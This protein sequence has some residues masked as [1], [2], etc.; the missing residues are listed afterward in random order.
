M[1]K[2][3]RTRKATPAGVTCSCLVLCDDVQVNYAT[4]KHTLHGII[5]GMVAR[6]LPMGVGPCVAYVRLSNVHSNQRVLI[7]FEHAD[8]ST[9]LWA[10][11]A[12]LIN[13]NDPLAVHTLMTRV[14]PFLIDRAGRYLLIASHNGVPVA[15][16][17]IEIRTP[18]MGIT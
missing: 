15:Q 6:E 2:K 13:R 14:P 5:G 17:P 16:A 4:A 7:S 18:D 11:Q 3:A 9:R 10:F 12:E 1:A 8:S